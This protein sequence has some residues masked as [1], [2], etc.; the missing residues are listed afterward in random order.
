MTDAKKQHFFCP[1]KSSFDRAKI[2]KE[3]TAGIF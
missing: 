2:G 1:P 3:A